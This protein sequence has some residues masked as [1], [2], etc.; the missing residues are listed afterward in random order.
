MGNRSR[1]YGQAAWDRS[2]AN[3]I[4]RRETFLEQYRANP[5][6]FLPGAVSFGLYRQDVTQKALETLAA[7][8]IDS[9][10]ARMIS[11]GGPV[12]AWSKP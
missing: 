3:R 6:N 2:E 7:N 11:V 9:H 12:I 8:W 10:N 5:C 1:L 4:K